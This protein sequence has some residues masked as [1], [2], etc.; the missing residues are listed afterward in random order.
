MPCPGPQG[1]SPI[2]V[3]RNW[4]NAATLF[5]PCGTGWHYTRNHLDYL[6]NVFGIK[7][8]LRQCPC[9]KTGTMITIE[10]FG[11]R[12]PPKKYLFEIKDAPV[13]KN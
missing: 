10:V 13:F 11:K 7:T 9:C 4:P 8:M 12:G 3:A 5:P 1:G 2:F 6:I